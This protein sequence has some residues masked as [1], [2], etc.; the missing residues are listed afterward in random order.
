M[1]LK[2][3]KSQLGAPRI[4]TFAMVS[5]EALCELDG[6]IKSHP[7]AA[8]LLTKLVRHLP[9]GTSGVVVA[10]RQSLAEL[11]D[12]SIPTIQRAISVLKGGGWVQS[13]RVSGAYA[14][15]IN[16]R[17]AWRG[18]RGDIPM[19]VFSATVI[20]ARSE[21]DEDGLNPPP[22]KTV[23]IT[24]S[25]EQVI[26]SEPFAKPPTQMRVEGMEPS[27]Q[28]E[29]EARGQLRIDQDTGEIPPLIAMTNA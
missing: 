23:P 3:T 21:Q 4:G 8:R 12:C 9:A 16:A 11:M 27:I 14:L 1:H 19:A 10:S 20:A 6:L 7:M 29:L 22:M 28:T 17:V 18:D 2:A 13:M 15:A 26:A 25:N 24:Y 5:D